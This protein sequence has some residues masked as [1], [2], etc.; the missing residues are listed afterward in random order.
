MS[1]YS[2]FFLFTDCFSRGLLKEARGQLAGLKR[3][4]L[5]LEML[6]RAV[7][8][9]LKKRLAESSS[10]TTSSSTSG[11]KSS[12]SKKRSRDSSDRSAG[13]SSSK[14]REDGEGERTKK[15]KLDDTT[16]ISS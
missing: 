3:R 8:T 13:S 12:G 2:L 9:G 14:R 10:T 11:G 6:G 7:Q 4:K 1:S 16:K 15:T 5:A